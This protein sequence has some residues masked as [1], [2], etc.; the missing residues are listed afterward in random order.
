MPA[1]GNEYT[2][3]CRTA[4]WDGTWSKD[5]TVKRYQ[6]FCAGYRGDDNHVYFE[7]LYFRL[8]WCV[9]VHEEIAEMLALPRGAQI[10]HDLCLAGA[11]RAGKTRVI[12]EEIKDR[13]PIRGKEGLSIPF[14]YVPM[15][16]VPSPLTVGQAILYWL[17]DP[18]WSST[19]N[20]T[21]RVVRIAEV[22]DQVGLRILAIDDLQHLVDSRGQKVQHMTADFLKEVGFY[23]GVPMI[24]CGLERMMRIFEVNEQ[25]AG[26]TNATIVFRRL[27]WNRKNDRALFTKMVELVV[28]EI[29]SHMGSV[30]EVTPAFVF[31]MYCATGGIPGYLFRVLRVAVVKCERVRSPLNERSIQRAAFTVVARRSAWPKGI[32]PFHQEFPTDA[33]KAILDQVNKIG[34]GVGPGT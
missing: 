17:G 21:T 8:P 7:R 10:E 23:I 12:R 20:P 15:P 3:T 1:D 2:Q 14:G 18:T 11:F 5:P 27:D 22:A 19:R 32:D 34:I 33:S 30:V 31:R 4:R 16:A 28:G 29:K 9:K 13:I 6:E 25:L 26:R 24:F